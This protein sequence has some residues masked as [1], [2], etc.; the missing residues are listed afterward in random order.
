[1]HEHL[2]GVEMA[3]QPVRTA[4]STHRSVTVTV[5]LALTLPLPLT[6]GNFG[7]HHVS[8][9]ELSAYLLNGLVLTLT[10]ALTLSLT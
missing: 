1:M 5:T 3:P 9:R 8:P 4:A 2:G 7:S 10:L 6:Q